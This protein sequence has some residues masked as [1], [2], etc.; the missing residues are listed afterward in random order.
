[1][2]PGS[3]DVY[4]SADVF[5]D[6][7]AIATH[8]ERWT[9]DRAAA[10]RTVDAIRGFVKALSVFPHRGTCREDLLPGLR[11]VPF[12]KRTAIAFTVDEAE[13]RV[14][15][16]RVFYGGQDYETVMRDQRIS[17]Q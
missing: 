8:I 9:E 16:L 12:G 6:Y 17:N 1:M 5:D 15:I 3:Y 10:D 4:E 13:G 14:N 7:V 2:I 11:V